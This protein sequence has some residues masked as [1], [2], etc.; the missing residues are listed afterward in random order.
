MSTR[1][2]DWLLLQ[3]RR[4][5]SRLLRA[6]AQ[7]G[8]G[9]DPRN[10]AVL[11][12]SVDSF[13]DRIFAKLLLRL[14]R[15][16]EYQRDLNRISSLKRVTADEFTSSMLTEEYTLLQRYFRINTHYKLDLLK[17]Y[18][19]NR[20]QLESPGQ[21]AGME[22]W[23][24]YT[25]LQQS[26]RSS[27][28]G[29]HASVLSMLEEKI[30]SCEKKYLS[31]L[32]SRFCSLV[33]RQFQEKAAKVRTCT[34][35][36]L[37]AGHFLRDFSPRRR[38]IQ[39]AS[40]DGGYEQATLS[41]VKQDSFSRSDPPPENGGTDARQ[42]AGA[43]RKPGSRLRTG[44]AAGRRGAFEG[45]L[46][47]GAQGGKTGSPPGGGRS[48]RSAYDRLADDLM[49]GRS[50]GDRPRDPL[51]DRRG[52]GTGDGSGEGADQALDPG[53]AAAGGL[54]D[55]GSTGSDPASS[56][57]KEPSSAFP[58][59]PDPVQSTGRSGGEDSPPAPGAGMSPESGSRSS[60]S[61]SGEAPV[62][63]EQA[64]SGTGDST[65]ASSSSWSPDTPSPGASRGGRFATPEWEW[66]LD[67]GEPATG[68]SAGGTAGEEASG[69]PSRDGSP[70]QPGAGDAAGVE[71]RDPG[72]P[73]AGDGAG[74]AIPGSDSS[75]SPGG[76][77]AGK[78][79]PSGGS[80]AGGSRSD[81]AETESPVPHEAADQSAAPGSDP[82]TGAGTAP[83]SGA[84]P[85]RE[86]GETAAGEQSG[87]T[88]SPDQAEPGT[89]H[90]GD[91]SQ[92]LEP[93]PEEG[94]IPVLDLSFMLD[95]AGEVPRNGGN[96]VPA[97]SREDLRGTG[98]LVAGAPLPDLPEDDDLGFESLEDMLRD[99]G[100]STGG[101]YDENGIYD[102]HPDYFW[103][104]QYWN[105]ASWTRD[106][107]AEMEDE[108]GEEKSPETPPA[109]SGAEDRSSEAEKEL[110]R[111]FEELADDLIHTRGTRFGLPGISDGFLAED[112]RSDYVHFFSIIENNTGIQKLLKHLGRSMGL[113]RNSRDRQRSRSTTSSRGGSPAPGSVSGI[114]MGRE[115]SYVLPEELVK[116]ADSDTEH[117]FDISYLENNLL[118]FDLK[119]IAG[120]SHGG[121]DRIRSSPR[122][123]RGPV[124]LCVDTSSSMQGVPESYA[125]ATVMSLALKCHD[126]GRDCY[127]INFSVKIEKL[128]L[129]E[130]DADVEGKLL[131]FLSKSFNGGSD[132]DEALMECLSLMH[133]DPRFYRSDVLCV[134]DGQIRFSERL[135]AMV[136]RRRQHEHNRFYELVIGSMANE[137]YWLEARESLRD[138][139]SIFDRLYE[140][141][142]D[143]RWMREISI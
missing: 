73:S 133:N 24:A 33:T 13:I 89:G 35:L 77:G 49:A 143:G 5:L 140:L 119:G 125:K 88:G 18:F 47:R 76:E 70:G 58:G 71:N 6:E 39:P 120:V 79:T 65:V 106:S 90:A 36:N 121:S 31:D 112:D 75:S 63:G 103:T 100:L 25:R 37:P 95:P 138:Q 91:G 123:G 42:G 59:S 114:T 56:G 66:S 11:R 74:S 111:Y 14:E 23:N 50:P 135:A 94:G 20:Y 78:G 21:N 72:G 40:R 19:K 139:S 115:I 41:N 141:S 128:V 81:P 54:R 17:K 53:S 22:E 60:S 32:S 102:P 51:R 98:K 52:A 118:L 131:K 1:G 134:T 69:E 9:A 30:A 62:S 28:E 10:L 48:R 29:A 110:E 122:R 64:S 129:R 101:S 105:T 45:A 44:G 8:G 137:A 108:P 117:I 99:L 34:R 96:A 127:V 3:A 15:D 7:D 82:G 80:A 61:A 57:G 16:D 142:T 130:D 92:D 67:P 86:G 132:L 68:T 2:N 26:N 38:R 124:V 116:I 126:A 113:D 87:E 43:G 93:L 4:T 27:L 136:R 97:G 12:R 55:P 109:A 104:H 83:G 85:S 84:D 107:E 46:G